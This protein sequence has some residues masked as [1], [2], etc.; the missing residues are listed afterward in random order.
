MQNE[1]NR[2]MKRIN[3]KSD[4]DFILRLK[5]CE[6]NAV[7]WP[8]YD[9]TAKFWTE[10]K[11]NSFA[12]G[13][14]GGA[15]VNCYNDDGQIHIVANGH[16]LSAG[17]LNVEFTA[18]LPNGTYPDGSERI[19]VP[20]P[21][22]I[23]LIR[24]AAPCPESFEVE[25]ML[26]YI[27]GEPF[28]YEDF[29]PEQIAEL[30]RPAT[31]AAARADAATGACIAA[32]ADAVTAT[33]AAN[34][35]AGLANE[36][37]TLAQGAAN[38]AT[39]ANEAMGAAE[40]VR[41]A[42]EDKRIEAE[43]R[44][45]TAETTRAVA[46][47]ERTES[48]TAREDAEASRVSAEETRRTA[49]DAR[50][51]AESL[52]VTSEDKRAESES[53]RA[54]A[55]NRRKEAE[56]ARADAEAD[57]ETAETERAE[58]ES[59]RSAQFAE[60]GVELDNKADRRE[61]SNVLAEEPLSG[62]NFPD[63]GTYTR[64]ELKKD[65]FIDMWNN[66]CGEYGTYN[67]TTGYFELNGLTDITYEEAIEIY[68]AGALHPYYCFC[69]YRGKEIRT[70]L[71]VNTILTSPSSVMGYVFYTSSIEIANVN[72]LTPGDR[73]FESCKNLRT[74]KGILNLPITDKN[75]FTN[76]TQLKD[77]TAVVSESINLKSSHLLSLESLQYMVANAKNTS[78][79]TITVHPDVYVKLTD[80]TNTEWNK[81]LTDAAAKQIIFATV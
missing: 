80:T 35:A 27:K 71:V 2:K 16:K 54:A 6:G 3:Y 1:H 7:G 31:E 30:Q 65:L 10:Q 56:T 14:K 75:I 55:E 78:A 8:D 51:A 32:T 12:A 74:I 17:V 28:R 43:R 67:A 52:R 26:P 62:D 40:N 23:E 4:F 79:I 49:E 81:V 59:G 77:I 39:A 53:E 13:C 5:D 29:T 33:E 69:L 61:L 36:K 66:A 34:E 50:T 57:R 11:I 18:E 20:V 21:L 64:E 41:A 9:W 22:E 44:R 76:C 60:W 68:E 47:N 24:A 58:A 48:E 42:N 63:I 37:A 70:N 38:A 45:V 73:C 19:A 46:E 25:V 72:K 15:C